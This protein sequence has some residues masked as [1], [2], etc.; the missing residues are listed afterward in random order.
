MDANRHI[1]QK[2]RVKGEESP[3]FTGWLASNRSHIAE[4]FNELGYKV[5]AEIGVQAGRN[6]YVLFQK[7]PNLKLFCVDPWVPWD[8]GRP[9]QHKQNMF[10]Y[11]AKRRL[12]G[13]NVV[14]IRKTS[15]EALS[16]I[17][18]GSLDFVYIDGQHDFDNVM[19]DIIEWSKKVRTGGI[20]S[21]HDYY[22]GPSVGVIPAVRAY[23][24]GHGINEWYMTNE[25]VE[26]PSF[27]WVKS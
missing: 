12:T 13:C 10:F 5:G 7:N 20:I 24:E 22:Q 1:Q 16:E 27:F 21:G 4:L 26:K 19:M 17:S 9:T 8:G 11:Q 18:D 6:A 3:P 25:Y 14:F 15:M 23:V 2:F